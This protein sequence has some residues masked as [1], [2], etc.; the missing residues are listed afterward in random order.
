MLESSYSEAA[1]EVLSILTYTEESVLNKIPKSFIDFLTN[2]ASRT[3]K[4]TFDF[5]SSLKDLN[6]KEKTKEI[7]G[8]IYI[9]WLCDDEQRKN[10]ITQIKK[11]K[12]ENKNTVSYSD[13]MFI[14]PKNDKTLNHIETNNNSDLLN[15]E[16]I[17]YKEE[18]FFIA[19]IKN[20]F[21]RL[22]K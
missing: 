18:N 21:K 17:E 7:L 16:M 22:K 15:S 8:F 3:Y 9:S 12:E 4:F 14:F 2:I 5:N 1:V 11:Q 10:Y 6:L 20:I 19:F 13:N